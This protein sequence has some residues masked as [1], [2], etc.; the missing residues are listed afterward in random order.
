MNPNTMSLVLA[1][2][3]GMA[4]TAALLAR[5]TAKPQVQTAP[6]AVLTDVSST[7]ADLAATPETAVPDTAEN[8][9]DADEIEWQDCDDVYRPTPVVA[10]DFVRTLG[11]TRPPIILPQQSYIFVRRSVLEKIQ[12]HLQNNVQVEQGG[13]VLGQA[14]VDMALGATFLVVH[15]ALP[16]LDGIET[17]TFFGYTTASWQTLTPQL[18]QMDAD[19]TLLGSY[20][21]H[22]DMGVFLSAT[23]LDTQEDVFSADWQLALV[24]DP[25]RDE[26]GF[27]VGKDGQPCADWYYI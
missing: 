11:L 14:F 12:A 22:P 27:F 8:L 25:V 10:S 4:L 26:I 13:L 16:A 3:G 15:D 17:P 19:W 5:L 7:G 20:H 9:A 21:S 6:N 24:I 1:G 18:Q 23:D 2:V